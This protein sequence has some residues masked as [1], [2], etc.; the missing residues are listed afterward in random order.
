LLVLEFY[1]FLIMAGDENNPNSSNVEN[2]ELEENVTNA[3]FMIKSPEER[4]NV[5]RSYKILLNSTAQLDEQGLEEVD[6]RSLGKIIKRS[7]KLHCQIDNAQD[8]MLDAQVFK[9]VSRQ[10]REMVS[11]VSTNAQSFTNSE[12]AEK[13]QA[14]FDGDFVINQENSSVSPTYQCF[15]LL[16][17]RF[18][19][20]FQRIPSLSFLNGSIPYEISNEVAEKKVRQ[21]RKSLVGD[22]SGLATQALENADDI[23]ESGASMTELLVKSTKKQLFEAYESNDRQPLSYFLFVLDPTSFCKTVENIFHL[24]F[25]IKENCATI[26]IEDDLP[27]V[28]PIK[29]SKYASKGKEQDKNQVILSLTMDEWEELVEIFGLQNKKAQIQHDFKSIKAQNKRARK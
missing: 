11:N 8:A 5:R 2:D 13:L 18:I 16:G 1:N 7:S 9:Q 6:K 4:K 10:T 14:F 25:L 22:G 17:Q 21:S 12:F 29:I 24:S 23:P 20:R 26:F 27:M 19:N 28:E 15:Q 3:T